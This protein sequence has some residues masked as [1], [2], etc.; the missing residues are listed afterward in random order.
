MDEFLEHSSAASEFIRRHGGNAK[1]E[2]LKGV[3]KALKAADTE[4]EAYYRQIFDEIMT[5]EESVRRLHHLQLRS[6]KQ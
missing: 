3:L 6:P 2:A 5:L 4:A 1:R